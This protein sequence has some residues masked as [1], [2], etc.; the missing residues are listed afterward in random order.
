MELII[1]DPDV[2]FGIV[3]VHLDFVR[4]A[5]AGCIEESVV[6]RPPLHQLAGAI[7][8]ENHVVIPALPATFLDRLTGRAQ[9]IIVA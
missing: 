8:H 1:E 6:L 5:P 3:R 9:S 2:F 7:D 4:T